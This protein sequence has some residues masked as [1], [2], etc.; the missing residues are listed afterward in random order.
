MCRWCVLNKHDSNDALLHVLDLIPQVDA[1][2]FISGNPFT[3]N[4]AR[5]VTR[6]NTVCGLPMALS[7]APA[8]NLFECYDWTNDSKRATLCMYMQVGLS[9]VPSN[10]VCAAG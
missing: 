7:F 6:T 5:H 9:V 4:A 3:L 1:F 2:G 10:N 8:T